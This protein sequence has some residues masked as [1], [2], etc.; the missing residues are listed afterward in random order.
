MHPCPL[1]TSGRKHLQ[2]PPPPQPCYSQC[3]TLAFT[4]HHPPHPAHSPPRPNPPA[5]VLSS[6]PPQPPYSL[7]VFSAHASCPRHSPATTC[8]SPLRKKKCFIRVMSNLPFLPFP[9][10]HAALQTANRSLEA[11]RAANSSFF[12]G[13]K[14]CKN[15]DKNCANTVDPHFVSTGS[16]IW[17]T[18]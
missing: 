4:A 10:S 9:S 3:A 11:L 14:P 5:S 8:Q 1:T 2:A 6:C 7:C 18:I 17:Y 13:L 12:S 15:S 16:C